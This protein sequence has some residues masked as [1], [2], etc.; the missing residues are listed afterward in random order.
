MILRIAILSLLLGVSPLLYAAPTCVVDNTGGVPRATINFTAPTVQTDGTPIP[1]G[2]V[3]TYNLYQSTTSGAEVKVAS[4]TTLSITVNTGIVDGTTYYW[5][6]TTSDTSGEGPPS[7]EVCKTFHAA[8]PGAVTITIT[9][10]RNATPLLPVAAMRCARQFMT[11]C[12]ARRLFAGV[13][14]EDSDMTRIV[15]D[16][17]GQYDLAHVVALT[18]VPRTNSS[19]VPPSA[20]PPTAK[21]WFEGTGGLQTLLDYAD[22]EAAWLNVKKAEGHPGDRPVF[23]PPP[24]QSS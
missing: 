11:G 7:N 14:L 22:T 6:V 15:S 9:Q 10:N 5:Y 3:L 20:L 18:K 4:S 13:L 8:L 16:A 12:R 24:T 23:D 21:L 17:N 19:T 2:T 1:T